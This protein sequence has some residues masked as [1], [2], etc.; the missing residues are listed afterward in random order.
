[1]KQNLWGTILL[2]VVLLAL[3]AVGLIYWFKYRPAD[4]R[5]LCAQ[6]EKVNRRP[7]PPWDERK[8]IVRTYQQCLEDNGIDK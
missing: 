3:T 8:R 4:I 5:E 6:E 1:M 2:L 7:R